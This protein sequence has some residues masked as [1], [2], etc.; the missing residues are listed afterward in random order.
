[1]S[2]MNRSNHP[3]CLIFPMG[4]EAAPFLHRVEVKRR[5]Q[6]G[7]ATYR[8]AFF[9]TRSVLVVRSGIGAVR[10]ATAVRALEMRPIAILSVGTAGSLVRD[11]GIGEF[12]VA[13]E[14]IADT[15]P[16]EVVMCD[17]SL[18]TAVA[19]ACQAEGRPHRL[20]RIVTARGAVI[21]REDRSRLH[22]LTGACAV[23]MESHAVA[24]EARKLQIPFTAVRVISDDLN[25]PDLPDAT[26][27]RKAWRNPWK[28]PQELA[29]FLRWRLFLRDFRRAIRL[30]SPVLIRLIRSE[31]CHFRG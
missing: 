29:A 19:K 31:G 21:T 9:E 4:I 23:D 30:L 18:A 16:R 28:L 22:H 7:H 6:M 11:L 24:V 27:L 8:E 12:V 14:T 10:A 1:M 13:S 25:S 17:S 26:S 3:L 15:E 2:E 5:W 20:G